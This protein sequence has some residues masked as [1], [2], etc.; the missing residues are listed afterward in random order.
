MYCIDETRSVVLGHQI[1]A[2]HGGTAE[3]QGTGVPHEGN[4]DGNQRQAVESQKPQAQ[5]QGG[6]QGTAVGAVASVG[7]T[8]GQLL[9]AVGDSAMVEIA[10]EPHL[11]FEMTVA[12]VAVDPLK[13][14][15]EN[16]VATLTSGDGSYEK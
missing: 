3:S 14:F 2:V 16:A 5:A 11:H 13:H 9:G 4:A 10:K 12:G 8:E 6:E 15:T 1:A 7:V